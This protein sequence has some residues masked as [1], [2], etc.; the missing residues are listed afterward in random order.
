MQIPL[1]YDIKTES[2]H[3]ICFTAKSL[4]FVLLFIILD[5]LLGHFL[6]YGIKQYYDLGKPCDVLF[7]GYSTTKCAVDKEFLQKQTGLKISKFAMEGANA[8][9]R[10]TMLKYYLSTHNPPKVIFYDVCQFT[11]SKPDT[12]S[13]NSYQNFYPFMDDYMVRK[14][15][16]GKCLSKFEWYVKS[17]FACSRYNERTIQRSLMGYTGEQVPSKDR[18]D[19]SLII[20]NY[21]KGIFRKITFDKNIIEA[22]ECSLSL[23]KSRGVKVVLLNLPY[24]HLLNE[25]QPNEYLQA[26]EK[27][28]SYVG[29]ENCV[30]LIDLNLKFQYQYEIFAD[31]IHLNQKGKEFIS[32]ALR[33]IIDS[34]PDSE[35]RSTEP[36]L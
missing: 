23:A 17:G 14:Y 35:N 29:E 22:F 28:K 32:A 26:I 36:I 34:I 27:L 4:A 16:A 31:P 24:L 13:T 12:P 30:A 10:H 19:I 7:I 8:E 18:I 2:R 20:S 25:C 33:D 21:S 11:F 5:R 9:D 1:F 3:L 6:F 15:V